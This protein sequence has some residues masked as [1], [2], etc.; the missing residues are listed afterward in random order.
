MDLIDFVTRVFCLCDDLPPPRRLRQSGFAPTLADSEILTMEIAGEFLGIDADA[1]VYRF[2][3]PPPQPALSR[4]ATWGTV[5]L[6]IQ[7]RNVRT[8]AKIM[9]QVVPEAL[10]SRAPSSVA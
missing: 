9:C 8:C 2:F 3:F 7:L 5:Q 6:D 10:P 4:P 1:G